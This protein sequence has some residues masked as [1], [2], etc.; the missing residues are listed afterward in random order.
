MAKCALLALMVE[1]EPEKVDQEVLVR[2]ILKAHQQ[3]STFEKPL[4]S[5][6][7]VLPI[8]FDHPSICEAEQRYMTMQ[9]DK[10]VYVPDNVSYVQE[11]NGLGSRTEVF[12]V[13][14]KARFIVIAVGFMTGLPLLWPLDPCARLT[15]QK[16]NPT[17]ISTPP[18]TVGLGG[19]MFCIYPADQPGGYMMLAR[20]IPVWDTYALRPGFREAKP[21]L[22][23]PFDVVEFQEVNFDEFQDI[24]RRFE[25]GT[26][27]IQIEETTFDVKTELAREHKI[28]E[29]PDAIE[30]RKKQKAAEEQ[31]RL[32]EEQLLAEWQSSQEKGRAIVPQDYDEKPGVKVSSPQVG[33]IWKVLVKPG[34]IVQKGKTLV[35]LEA[36]KMEIPVAAGEAHDGLVVK[37]VFA[38]EGILVSPG[39]LLVLLDKPD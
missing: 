13:L 8:V 25:A 35:V 16:Y 5:R 4:P 30:F 15:S 38:Q 11:N 24:W 6:R 9:R 36:M 2:T 23:E 22:C 10:A 39:T 21:W 17:R 37:E 27:E 20:S 29:L 26:Y 19:G 1:Y 28:S 34:D 3:S 7:F 14:Q 18:G 32:R 33:K 12:H 31:M